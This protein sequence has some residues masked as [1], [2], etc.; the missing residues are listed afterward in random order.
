M[1]LE[2]NQ[3]KWF[4]VCEVWGVVAGGLGDIPNPVIEPGSPTLAGRFFTTEPPGKPIR[5]M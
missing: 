1:G 4:T 2:G 3:G 5:G